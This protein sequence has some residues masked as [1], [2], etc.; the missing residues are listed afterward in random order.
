MMF[1]VWFNYRGSPRWRA[2]VDEAQRDS[3]VEFLEATEGVTDI[4][5]INVEG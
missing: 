2:A 5:V 1:E 4:Q 3:T